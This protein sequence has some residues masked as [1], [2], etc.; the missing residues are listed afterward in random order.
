LV[1]IVPV[2]ISVAYFTLLERKFLSAIQRR[3]GPNVVG[4]YGLLTP[5]ADGFKLL[6]KETVIPSNANKFLFILAPVLTF[7][8]ALLS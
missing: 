4:V 8:L 6:L 1:L 5:L 3:S 2:L 7:S